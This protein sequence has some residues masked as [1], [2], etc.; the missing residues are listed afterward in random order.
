MAESRKNS[1]LK[2][3]VVYGLG[4][5]LLQASGIVLLP[6]YTRYLVPADFGILEILE[7]TGS[8]LTILLMVNGVRGAAF[9]FFCQARDD[10]ERARIVAT[11]S[12]VVWL[13]I[14]VGLLAVLA[15]AQPLSRFL[16]IDDARL[17]VLGLAASIAQLLPMLPMA[18]MQARVQS[19]GYI[20]ASLM[21]MISRV[22]IVVAA[23]AWGGWGVWGVL[24]GT[25]IASLVAGGVLTALELRRWGFHPDRSKLM[26]VVRFAWPFMPG[27]LCGFVLFSGDRFFLLQYCGADEVGVYALGSRLAGIVGTVAFTP[28]F[29]VWSAWLYGVY[30]QPD[31]DRAVGRMITRLLTPYVF[32]GAGVCLFRREILLVFGTAEYAGAALVI[33]PLIAARFFITAQVLF[34]GAFYVYRRTG[35]KL[36]ITI[37]ATAVILVLFYLLIPRYQALGAALAAVGAFFAYAAATHLVSQSVF[38]VRYEYGRV[39]ALLAGGVAVVLLA[40][41]FDFGIMDIPAKAA[42]MAAWPA[43]LW[44]TGWVSKEEKSLVVDSLTRMLRRLRCLPADGAGDNDAPAAKPAESRQRA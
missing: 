36:G 29:K 33:P 34:D 10:A 12:L 13:G 22:A 39:A 9:S 37:F 43:V 21:T 8:V 41:Q 6:L 14:L 26:P 44:I 15:A 32:V 25:L 16:G 1:F 17:T 5:L 20:L 18:F 2:N 3:A 19:V 42:L 7:R 38:R 28:L 40:G 35:L 23:V 4:S 30:R 27:G 24:W 11:V 31:G